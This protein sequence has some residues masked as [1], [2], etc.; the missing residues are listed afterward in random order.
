MLLSTVDRALVEE[1]L[2][3]AFYSPAALSVEAWLDEMG[4][5]RSDRLDSLV[6]FVASAFYEGIADRYKPHGTP[7]VR[8]GDVRLGTVALDKAVF[9][10]DSVAADTDGLKTVRHP[11][12]VL[13]KGGSV[14]RP[15]V[16]AEPGTYAVS[17]DVIGLQPL[18]ETSIGRLLF[19]LA[20]GP[21][22]TQVLRGASRQVQAHLTLERLE[23]LR[24]PAIS[25][26]AESSLTDA[27]E[28]LRRA[29]RDFAQRRNRLDNLFSKT[30]PF[31]ELEVPRLAYAA[32]RTEAFRTRMDVAYY[33]P[34]FAAAAKAAHESDWVELSA[35][36]GVS[37]DGDTWNRDSVSASSFVSYVPLAAIEP[38]ACRIAHPMEQRAW[39][40][41]TRAKWIVKQGDVLVPSLLD[42][43][44]RVGF[45][46]RFDVRAIASSGFHLVRPGSVDEGLRIAAYMTSR[47]AHQQILRAGS[48]TR[49]RS[50]N[51]DMLLNLLIPP[52]DSPGVSDVPN[53]MR[54]IRIAAERLHQAWR[55]GVT[56]AEEI[57]GWEGRSA[58]EED[59][60][61]YLETEPECG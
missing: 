56:L 34:G 4:S 49:F 10:D 18:S 28:N 20:S 36:D 37:F 9:L 32:H 14:G 43:L 48:G 15:G 40:V 2:D 22:Q 58:E 30:D 45:V 29:R 1:R 6:E 12:L 61:S 47:G 55:E 39:S 13:T 5:D 53:M 44:D 52:R 33:R 3:P 31:A 8:V 27:Y 54:E 51:K 7:L 46:D 41:P 24:V 19:F 35:L 59:D 17:R 42:C 50:I 23:N 11:S 25:T 21:G 38:F 57:M 26:A 60:L 16:T